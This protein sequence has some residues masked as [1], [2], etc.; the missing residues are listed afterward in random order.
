MNDPPIHL[1]L[2]NLEG[3]NLPCRLAPLAHLAAI[4]YSEAAIPQLVA[5][6]VLDI[7]WLLH[8]RWWGFGEHGH[9]GYVYD[10]VA[11]GASEF[12]EG[13]VE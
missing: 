13:W 9:C 1:T 8:D 4:A 5:S 10:P 2:N 11:V 3:N 12:G 7:L 6:D